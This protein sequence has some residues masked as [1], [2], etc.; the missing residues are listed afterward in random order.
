[1]KAAVAPAWRPGA[2]ARR[3]ATLGGARG[4]AALLGL[5]GVML[6]ARALDPGQL[7]H[8]SLAPAVQGYALHLG[9]FGL[10]SVVTT[11]AARAGRALPT[12]IR[13]YLG[14]RLVLSLAT[15]GF[16]MLAATLARPQDAFLIGLVTLSILP[17][18]LQLDWLALVDDRAG[19]A[20]GLLLIRPIA[21]LLLI[22]LWRDDLTP[23]SLA[24][25]YLASWALAA[26]AS[27][28]A[29]HRP[30]SPHAG[31]LPASGGM[32][33]RG[34]SLA[35]VTVTNQ[36][37][38]SADLLVV[39]WSLGAATASDYYLAGQIV[40]AALLFANAS[41]QIALARLPGLVGEPQLFA[42]AMGAEAKHLLCLA[43][44]IALGL[45]VVAPSLLP[46]LFGAEHGGAVVALWWLLPWFLLQNLTT[47]LQAG[48]TAAGCERA[49]LRANLVLLLALAPGLALAAAGGTLAGFA[50][51]RT[52]AELARLAMLGAALRSALP[53]PPRHPTGRRSRPGPAAAPSAHPAMAAP[54]PRA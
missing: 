20:A 48:L 54:P 8:W 28:A 6:T 32:L 15:L 13:R 43:G 11:E 26:L 36:A 44:P 47:L 33:R 10:R 19:L 2:G 35:L 12:L 51:A 53:A 45:G 24:A 14:L 3:L 37:Q 42:A 40:V 18:A 21:F 41:G 31:G 25:C 46:V 7:G 49:V 16:V 50:A 1:V 23:I 39:G 38:L 27:W 52:V 34:A 5:A 9:E 17:I 4:L 22:G 29:L 30:G